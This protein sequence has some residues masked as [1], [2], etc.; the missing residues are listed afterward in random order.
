MGLE[1]RIIKLEDKV[2]MT[3]QKYPFDFLI[4]YDETMTQDD[5]Q[6]IM[7]ERTERSGTLSFVLLPK[8]NNN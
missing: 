7:E 3:K 6:K 4:E 5:I 1:N 8:K 2:E